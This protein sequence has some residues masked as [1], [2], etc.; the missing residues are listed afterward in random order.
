MLL[1]DLSPQGLRGQQLQDSLAAVNLTSNRNPIPFDS[2]KPAEWAGLRLGVGAATTRGLQR[3]D[4]ILLGEIIARAVERC[5]EGS[6][7][8]IEDDK[9]LVLGLCQRHPIY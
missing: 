8:S 2:A 6:D 7:S 9:R 4:M 5:V 3:D 1:L